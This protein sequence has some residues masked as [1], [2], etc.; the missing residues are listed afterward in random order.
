MRLVNSNRRQ[1]QEVRSIVLVEVA[2]IYAFRQAAIALSILQVAIPT[3]QVMV[4]LKLEL[5]P[6]AVLQ[7][8]LLDVGGT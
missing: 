4:N 2:K 1:P 5:S 3:V 7:T 6:E 8:L